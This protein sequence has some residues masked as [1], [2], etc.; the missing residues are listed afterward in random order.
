MNDPF[1]ELMAGLPRQGPGRAED[2][3]WAARA[4]GLKPEARICD[5]GCGTGADVPALL[6][7]AP[8]GRVTAVDSH[9][10]FID[11]LLARHGEAPRLTAYKG[12]MGHIKGPFDLVW[13]AGAVYF[14][15][16]G[17][18]L[19]LWRPAL[20][21]GGAVAFSHPCFFTETPSDPARLFWEGAKVDT[22]PELAARIKAA[23]WRLEAS[24]RLPDAAWEAYYQ[25]METRIAELRADPA[26]SADAA[27]QAV[28]DAA[29]AEIAAWRALRG[30][31][32]YLLCVARPA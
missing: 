9:G 4:A 26:W 23:G 13:S 14:L 24:R 2:V 11:R 12:D 29:A 10:P 20:A 3:A 1:L 17:K 21:P 16:V 8:G 15:G 6:A 22:E 19:A 31:T 18:A 25:P 5:A 7:A 28:L 32:G 27:R 30:E